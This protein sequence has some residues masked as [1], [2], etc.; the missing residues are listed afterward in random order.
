[1][2]AHTVLGTSTRKCP[3]KHVS[4][5]DELSSVIVAPRPRVISLGGTK[6]H[7]RLIWS[8][9]LLLLYVVGGAI[10]YAGWLSP[11]KCNIIVLCTFCF[12]LRYREFWRTARYECPILLLAAYFVV[13]GLMRG[14]SPLATTVYLYYSA[15]L[16]L[17]APAGR[18]LAK[19]LVT[20]NRTQVARHILVACLALELPIAAMQHLY[21]TA[22]AGHAAFRVGTIDAVFGTFQLNSDS[23]LSACCVMIVLIYSYTSRR[24][25]HILFVTCLSFAVIF[26]GHSK[27]MQGTYIM[28]L[29]PIFGV[30]LYH[31]TTIKRYNHI[32]KLVGWLLLFV[33]VAFAART[34]YGDL[35]QFQ[36]EAVSDYATRDDWVTAARLAP[37]GELFQSSLAQLIFGHGALTY[38]N[39]I[40]KNWLYNAGFSTAYSLSIDFGLV[41]LF[42]YLAYQI[43]II[44]S[45]SPY[46]TFA[47]FMCAVWLAFILF[48][49][50]LPNIAFIFALNFTVS[51]VMYYSYAERQKSSQAKLTW[52]DLR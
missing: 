38:Y 15:C 39:P 27:A 9:P 46:R 18:L 5:T 7:L 23:V 10:Q 37:W 24:L 4:R 12:L 43:R 42:G 47:I 19:E 21:A 49:D 16:L 34:I 35:A 28:L 25:S 52:S 3:G 14:T 20:R 32:F 51:F 8:L 40:T 2:T 31:R 11:T 33:I 41:G 26:L 22:F 6:K 29:L 45:V 44:F 1:M 48:N 30:T 17:A 13:S 36:S 50:V